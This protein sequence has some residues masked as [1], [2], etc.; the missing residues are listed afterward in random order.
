M[1]PMTRLNFVYREKVL[2]NV[3]AKSNLDENTPFGKLINTI[4]T[5]VKN[6]KILDAPFRPI[7][8]MCN[9]CNYKYNYIIPYETLNQD[10]IRILQTMKLDSKVQNY[11]YFKS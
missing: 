5:K 11:I 7:Y 3:Y 2:K 6:P 8:S 1:H 10:S 9:P 4:V